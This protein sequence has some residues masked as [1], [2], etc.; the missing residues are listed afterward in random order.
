[1]VVMRTSSSRFRREIFHSSELVNAGPIR[2][3]ES[4]YTK[5]KCY[6]PGF[7]FLLVM[8][9]KPLADG[10]MSRDEIFLG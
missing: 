9:R 8:F 2:V 3:C 6:L 4:D 1:M 10:G 7:Q 5:P